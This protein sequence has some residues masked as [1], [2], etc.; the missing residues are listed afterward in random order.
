[1]RRA[2]IFFS[3]IFVDSG[4]NFRCDLLTEKIQKSVYGTD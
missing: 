3:S 4:L 2:E 1:M